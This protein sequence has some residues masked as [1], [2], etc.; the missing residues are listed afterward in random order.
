MEAFLLFLTTSFLH[1]EPTFLT[2]CQPELFVNKHFQILKPAQME[3]QK[4]ALRTVTLK[5]PCESLIQ[6]KEHLPFFL[7]VEYLVYEDW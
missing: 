7:T 4:D 2:F 6:I 3:I 1:E 5:C